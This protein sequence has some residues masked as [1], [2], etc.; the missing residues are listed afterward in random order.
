VVYEKRT[1]YHSVQEGENNMSNDNLAR[2]RAVVEALAARSPEF[3]ASKAEWWLTRNE[4]FS[5]AYR[6]WFHCGNPVMWSLTGCK[7]RSL[8]VCNPPDLLDREHLADLWDVC[9]AILPDK[10]LCSALIRCIDPHEALMAAAEAALCIA[11][12]V[13]RG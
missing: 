11:G 3:R 6:Q 13:Q 2:S 12:E 9:R 10:V 1:A 4:Y 7:T 8:V 5:E